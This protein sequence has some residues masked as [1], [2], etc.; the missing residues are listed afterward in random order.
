MVDTSHPKPGDS[1]FYSQ[2]DTSASM[3]QTSRLCVGDY[4]TLLYGRFFPKVLVLQSPTE[5]RKKLHGLIF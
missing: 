5:R 1:E 3:G 4:F 2:A